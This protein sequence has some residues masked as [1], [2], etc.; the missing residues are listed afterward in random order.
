MLGKQKLNYNFGPLS[1]QWE[2]GPHLLSALAH[3]WISL[4]GSL[5]SLE[6]RRGCWASDCRFQA[7][8]LRNASFASSSTLN[9]LDTLCFPVCGGAGSSGLPPCHRSES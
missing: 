8:G 3:L 7:R 6:R 1:R 5:K 9:A 4:A 2:Q